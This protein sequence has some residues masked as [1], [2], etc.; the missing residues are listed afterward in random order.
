MDII[1]AGAGPAGMSCAIESA[2]LG[3]DTLIVSDG[4]PGGLVNAARRLDN[5][6][7]FERGISAQLWIR[8][9][10][11]RLASPRIRF[12]DTGVRRISAHGPDMLVTTTN[13]QLMARCVVLATG[14]RPV[15]FSPALPASKRIHRD[16]RTVPRD[17]SGQRAAVIGGSEAAVD[18]ALSLLDRGA[19]VRVF[20]RGTRL[21][22]RTAL[23]REFTDSTAEL[24]T[25]RTVVKVEADPYVTLCFD[26]KSRWS[27]EHLLVCVGRESRIDEIGLPQSGPLPGL[28]MAGDMLRDSDQR[29]IPAAMTDGIEMARRAFES[30]E[31]RRTT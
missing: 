25:G 13:G 29:F 3:M 22:G 8:D 20:A 4:P 28:F 17:L 30:L 10:A 1:V 21:R 16:I 14:T 15:A 7:G 27:S 24:D 6:P 23:L 12:V 11:T 18:T 9:M 31:S 5:I 26:D 19:M 2:T